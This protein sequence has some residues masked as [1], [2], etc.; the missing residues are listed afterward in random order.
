MECHFAG[1]TFSTVTRAAYQA[2]DILVLWLMQ[3]KPQERQMIT[4][5]I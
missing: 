2:L 1:F 4:F 3:Q 5:T